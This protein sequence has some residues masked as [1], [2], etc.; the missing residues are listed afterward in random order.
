M[1]NRDEA[2]N[3]IW[4]IATRLREV[5][6]NMGTAIKRASG[7]E[8]LLICEQSWTDLGLA[9]V[10]LEAL[11]RLHQTPAGQDIESSAVVQGVR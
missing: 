4:D 6:S 1:T 8:A 7:D 5:Q 3:L 2:R 11:D 10:S 9:L